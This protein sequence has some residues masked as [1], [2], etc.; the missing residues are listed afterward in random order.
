MVSLDKCSLLLVL[1]LAV[2]TAPAH[3]ARNVILIIGDGMDDQ[4][5]T[6][7]RNYL[8]GASGR[9]TLDSMPFRG[10]SQVLTVSEAGKT[11]Y[12]ADSANSATSMATGVVT[13]RGRI[14]TTAG[15]D[16]PLTTIVSLAQA[17]GLKTGLVSTA[18]V[19]DATP[20]AFVAHM[21]M[22]YCENPETIHGAKI[23]VITLP[24]CP[25]YTKAAGGPG[26]ISEQIAASAVDV[27]LGGGSKHFDM[28]AENTEQTVRS[29]AQDNGF[30]VIDSAAALADAPRDKKLLG[31]F[32]PSTMPVRLQGEGGREAEEPTP[33]WANLVN[34]Y[35]GSVELPATMRCEPN[36]AFASMP[37]LKQMT[38]AALA[39]LDNERGFFLMI[40]SASIDKQSHE[41]KPCGS[42]GEVAQLNEALDSALAFAENNPD[43]LIIVTADHSQAAQLVPATSL[44]DAYGIPVYTPGRVARIETPEG[45]ILGVNYATNSFSYEEHSGA[46]V[47]VFANDV[48]IGR[49]STMITQ[50]Q[51]FEIMRNYLFQPADPQTWQ[52]E[53]AGRL[54]EKNE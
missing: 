39:R 49:V 53:G 24:A 42:I 13:S 25:T 38:D 33:S 12:V 34:H 54:T 17:R 36:P 20:A 10:V 15:A 19:T 14:G 50:P 44:F 41:R 18:S 21:N 22:R 51:I 26:S 3:A 2:S 4:Q 29:Q 46:N 35:L 37:T 48:G 43:T 31:L 47:P 23:S 32:S 6:I 1:A 27:V 11:V 5:V 30:H 7:A 9:L 45:A 28:A 8:A 52:T 16:Q 40:E